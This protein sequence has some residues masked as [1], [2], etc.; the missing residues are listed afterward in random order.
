MRLARRPLYWGGGVAAGSK[1]EETGAGAATRPQRLVLNLSECW[2]LKNVSHRS[3]LITSTDHGTSA[4]EHKELSHAETPTIQTFQ[5]QRQ[6]SELS[7]STDQETISQES[8]HV[9][10]SVGSSLC[11]NML[12]LTALAQHS[13][14]A[15]MLP[16]H[17]PYQRL[18][19]IINNHQC[20]CPSSTSAACSTFH[21][22]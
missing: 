2:A 8:G 11:A 14:N 5:P 22:V 19:P 6:A 3:N 7:Q 16:E 9:G 4:C 12:V 17:A 20:L 1:C 15:N 21:K 10:S 13:D 18:L